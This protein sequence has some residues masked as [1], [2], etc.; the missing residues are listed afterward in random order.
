[1]LVYIQ[2]RKKESEK[3]IFNLNSTFYTKH[4]FLDFNKYENSYFHF[5]I[6]FNKCMFYL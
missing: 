4:R 3:M 5:I 6:L 2:G 1:M